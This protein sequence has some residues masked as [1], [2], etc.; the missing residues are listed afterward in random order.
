VNGQRW[1]YT[2]AASPLEPSR[3]KLQ[4]RQEVACDAMAD[5]GWGSQALWLESRHF[6]ETKD[7]FHH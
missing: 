5:D 3:S 4:A 1:S 7:E 2:L 6:D